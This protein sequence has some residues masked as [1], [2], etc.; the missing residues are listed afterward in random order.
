MN[1][2]K[3]RE[4]AKNTEKLASDFDSTMN[5]LK[6]SDVAAVFRVEA[7]KKLNSLVARAKRMNIPFKLDVEKA[8]DDLVNEKFPKVT[9]TKSEMGMVFNPPLSTFNLNE[10]MVS[11]YLNGETIRLGCHDLGS[12][13]YHEL[14]YVYEDGIWYGRYAGSYGTQYWL[15]EAPPRRP[16]Y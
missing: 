15:N 5:E 12:H 7:T 9:A 1:S 11:G 4:L 16:N 14:E 10:S 13:G 8:V 3:L 2:E 6:E